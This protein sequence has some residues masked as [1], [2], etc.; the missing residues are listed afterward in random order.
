[1]KTQITK[2]QKGF[3]LIEIL[4]A[5][6][7]FSVVMV[8]STSTIFSVIA[9]NRKSQAINSVVNN[10]NFSIESMVRDIKT[11]YRYK[12]DY[13]SMPDTMASALADDYTCMT[14]SVAES[15][16]L[17]VSTLTGEP[18]AVEYKFEGQSGEIPGRIMR[19]ERVE[20]DDGSTSITTAPLTSP[21]I[22]VTDVR[23][24]IN[25]RGIGSGTQPSVFLII[26]AEAADG[27]NKDAQISKYR[28]QTFI[29]QRI[30]NI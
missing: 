24:F 2:T 21:D 7:L 5:V 12:C 26:T 22:N 8:I 6:T 1:M 23:F 16:I 15:Q 10:L 19:T 18:S 28:I 30:L 25:S 27:G 29:S 13:G 17:F 20:A 9:G 11:G 4:V 3:T 14:P